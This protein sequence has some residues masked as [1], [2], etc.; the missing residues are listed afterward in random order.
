MS[1]DLFC[2]T[3]AILSMWFSILFVYLN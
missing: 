2:W 3:K 1:F